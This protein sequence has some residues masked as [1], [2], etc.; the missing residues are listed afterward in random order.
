MSTIRWGARAPYRVLVVTSPPMRGD[1][2]RALQHGIN[3]RHD[4]NHARNIGIVAADGEYGPATEA[5]ARRASFALGALASTQRKPGTT[6]GEQTYI[7]APNARP[8]T[9]IKRGKARVRG[10]HATGGPG[11]AAAIAAARSKRGVRESPA[12]SNKGGTGGFITAIQV[13]LLGWAGWPWCGAFV[14]W[15]CAQGGAKPTPRWRYTPWIVEDAKAGRGGFSGWRTTAQRAP[16]GSLV[17]F[18]FNGGGVDHVGLLVD[19]YEPGDDVVLSVD[20]N[21][22]G[23]NPADGGMVADARR[24]VGMVAGFALVDY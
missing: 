21:T 8:E 17:L 20:G 24:S 14:A 23:S 13:A 4:G 6:V 12:G 15:A 3:A 18:D 11:A 2:V 19:D 9:A 16:A 10:A 22:G 1:D 7:R 5:A